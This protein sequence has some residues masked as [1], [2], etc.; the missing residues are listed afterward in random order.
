MGVG[1]FV[2]T[3]CCG[4][5]GNCMQKERL[6]EG[7]RLMY[8][9]ILLELYNSVGANN[10]S[11]GDIVIPPVAE[12]YSRPFIYSTLEGNACKAS[13]TLECTITNARNAVGDGYACKATAIVERI[14]TNAPNVLRDGYACQLRAI[15]ECIISN[16]CQMTIVTKYNAYQRCT[17]IECKFVNACNVVGNSNARKIDAMLER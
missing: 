8:V 3:R 4:M 2:D 7:R 9:W 1:V 10:L 17:F 14:N 13:A 15:P 6:P 11:G 12:D 16:V 5:I